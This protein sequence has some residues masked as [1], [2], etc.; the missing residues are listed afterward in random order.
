MSANV[1]ILKLSLKKT[2]NSISTTYIRVLEIC[3]LCEYW[4]PY[5]INLQNHIKV[6]HFL[7]LVSYYRE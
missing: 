2:S 4:T 5:M 7:Y 6:A 1:V 3:D